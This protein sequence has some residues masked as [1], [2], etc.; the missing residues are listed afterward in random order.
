MIYFISDYHL[1]QELKVKE[2]GFSSLEE[3][4]E[5]IISGW[6][7]TVSDDDIVYILGDVSLR[8]DALT[9]FCEKTNGEKILILGNHDKFY[10]SFYKKYFSR[11]K[12]SKY[13]WYNE[14]KFILS[15]FPIHS[16]CLEENEYCI[17]G[18]IHEKT[19]NDPKLINVCCEVLNYKPI[20]VEQ[21]YRSLKND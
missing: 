16:A 1:G 20:S 10:F 21:I 2:R 19:I 11:I 12:Q 6:N 5:K 18:H 15:H 4:T 8:R 14:L 9:Y 17:H 13:L 3:M 7:S